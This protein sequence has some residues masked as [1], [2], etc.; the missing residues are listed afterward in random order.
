MKVV[1]IFELSEKN[2]KIF[3]AQFEGEEKNEEGE[4]QNAFSKL[5]A[6]WAD[7]GWFRSFFLKFKQDHFK[8][9][10]SRKLNS[11]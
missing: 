6:E 4:P 11:A 7:P 8:F 3:A 2:G 9:Y 10:G 5:R 1:C